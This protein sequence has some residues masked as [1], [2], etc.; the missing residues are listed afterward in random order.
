VR[1]I[2]AIVRTNFCAKHRW[3]EAPDPVAYLQHWHR[4]QF[5]VEL[6]V[7]QVHSDRDVEFIQVKQWLDRELED[8]REAFLGQKSCEMMAEEILQW[9]VEAGYNPVRCSVFEDGE[10]GAEVLL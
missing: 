1:I 6:V 5:H 4:H 10:N 9:A 2:N 3:L 8:W 7:A